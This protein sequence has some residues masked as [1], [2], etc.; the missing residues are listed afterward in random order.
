[1]CGFRLNVTCFSLGESDESVHCTLATFP[2][3][4]KLIPT[5]TSV[6]T[7]FLREEAK[8]SKEMSGNKERGITDLL[9]LKVVFL[10]KYMC[11]VCGIGAS[12]VN[13]CI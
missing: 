3:E 13:M 6:L 2:G 11:P 10:I 4:V 7:S 5:P 1:M 12:V 8:T 9:Q